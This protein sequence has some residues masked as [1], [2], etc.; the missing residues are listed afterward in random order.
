MR[1]KTSNMKTT[2]K[3]AFAGEDRD[4]VRWVTWVWRTRWASWGGVG[5][6]PGKAG[7][8]DEAQLHGGGGVAGVQPE[9]G[10]EEGGEVREQLEV[11]SPGCQVTDDV[12]RVCTM[13]SAV[14]QVNLPVPRQA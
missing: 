8:Q 2:P 12:L 9:E 13:K 7:Q 10:G 6:E 11:W 14:G 3:K 5:G 1:A 4:L